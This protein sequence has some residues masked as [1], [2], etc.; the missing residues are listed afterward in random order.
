MANITFEFEDPDY[1]NSEYTLYTECVSNPNIV[2]KTNSKIIVNNLEGVV[3]EQ[4]GINIK[5]TIPESFYLDNCL[6]DKWCFYIGKRCIT[7]NSS[8]VKYD[9]DKFCI[10]IPC[11]II[12]QSIL[13]V[14]ECPFSISFL[15]QYPNLII[16]YKY[17]TLNGN[18]DVLVSQNL[19]GI[20]NGDMYQYTSEIFI[21]SNI[22]DGCKFL[23]SYTI[24]NENKKCK[25]ESGTKSIC[26]IPSDSTY[27]KTANSN[28]YYRFFTLDTNGDKKYNNI[29]SFSSDFYFEIFTCCNTTDN[30][31]GFDGN[32]FFSSTGDPFLTYIVEKGNDNFFYSDKSYKVLVTRFDFINSHET[33]INFEQNTL[34]LTQNP[35][36]SSGTEKQSIGKYVGE[37][38]SLCNNECVYDANTKLLKGVRVCIQCPSQAIIDSGAEFTIYKSPENITQKW[39]DVCKN[40]VRQSEQ[41]Y[42]GISYVK[43]S[44]PGVPDIV[45][46]CSPNNQVTPPCPP[47][48]NITDTSLTNPFNGYLQFGSENDINICACEPT[49][50]SGTTLYYDSRR[51]PGASVMKKL[52]FYYKLECCEVDFAKDKITL[53]ILHPNFF[54]K[55]NNTNIKSLSNNISSFPSPVGGLDIY[56]DGKYVSCA[57]QS[58]INGCS[59][60]IDPNFP[61]P[62]LQPGQD[63]ADIHLPENSV[64]ETIDLDIEITYQS[65]KCGNVVKIMT[66]KVN[67]YNNCYKT[68]NKCNDD[69][70]FE[71]YLVDGNDKE[72]RNPVVGNFNLTGHFL[73]FRSRMGYSY[74]EKYGTT[75]IDNLV[76]MIFDPRAVSGILSD[77]L[78]INENY[79]S[80]A[81]CLVSDKF[82]DPNFRQCGGGVFPPAIIP[83][84]TYRHWI[85]F[86]TFKNLPYNV[87]KELM[88][89]KIPIEIYPSGGVCSYPA[90]AYASILFGS[91][92]IP[93]IGNN[94]STG[95]HQTTSCIFYA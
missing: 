89:M 76:V 11:R 24:Y 2:A 6:L 36:L 33:F 83:G 13:Q 53:K 43:V 46:D 82:I 3:I 34:Q 81:N 15:S 61:R 17:N 29:S 50:G 47:Y 18:A 94:V 1:P 72:V 41:Y 26:V 20:Q 27:L 40:G 37:P 38:G 71:L 51:V 55:Q 95:I 22:S 28:I 73:R 66:K 48:L 75:D 65:A 12:A 52:F 19:I 49:V 39:S 92:Q 31:K 80:Q 60:K 44:G 45:V 70:G 56:Y 58:K 25:Y 42:P 16:E 64:S 78:I 21:D 62:P 8:V 9:A 30:R 67:V 91:Y 63:L 87:G 85:D 88:C 7:D 68:N 14:K 74:E 84:N 23:L 4:N 35:C 10:D 57:K 93:N 90:P 77:R 5:I 59:V 32:I 69:D 54:F 79:K 86:K